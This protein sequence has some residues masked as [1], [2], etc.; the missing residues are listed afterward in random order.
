MGSQPRSDWIIPHI[1]PFFRIALAAS[2][3]MIKKSTLPKSNPAARDGGS[4]HTLNP[5]N[6][7]A[8]I[9]IIRT[10]YKQMNM[11]RHDDITAQHK[12]SF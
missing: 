7:D 4:Y 9:K 11:V 6:P 3:Q 8:Q 10:G 12:S 2:D 1:I 5:A